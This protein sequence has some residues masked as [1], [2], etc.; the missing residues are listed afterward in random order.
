MKTV[1]AQLILLMTL[2]ACQPQAEKK[3]SCGKNESFDA[4]SRSC[5]SITSLSAL[6]ASPIQQIPVNSLSSES[7]N[8]DTP[9]IVYL[10]Y[11]DANLDSALSCSVSAGA[12][13]S[14][15]ACAC[16][17]GVC[18]FTLSS[19]ANFYGVST[20]NYTVTDND[21]PSLSTIVNVTVNSLDDAPVGTLVGSVAIFEDTLTPV[22]LTYT[23][24]E[25]D[26]ATSC[27]IIS[28]T[29]LGVTT[30]ACVAGLCTAQLQG[31][32]NVSGVGIANITYQIYA[33]G[34]FSI[35]Q[36]LTVDITALDDAPIGSTSAASTSEDIPVAITLGYTDVESD[37]AT[38]CNITSTTNVTVSTACA[39]V[40]GVCS[41]GI[42]PNANLNSSNSTLG[43]SYTVTANALTSVA[44]AVTLTTSAVDDIPVGSNV[45]TSTNEDT[46]ITIPLPFTDVESNLATSCTISALGGGTVGA[47]SCVTLPAS[48]CEVTF[49]PS[50]NLATSGSFQYTVTAGAGTS[51]VKTVTVTLNAVNDNPVLPTL[52][53]LSANEGSPFVISFNVDEGGGTDEDIQ[54]LNFTVTSDNPTLLPNGNISVSFTEAGDASDDIVTITMIPV[55]AQNGTATITVQLDDDGAPV[56]TSSATFN[57]TVN[58]VSVIHNG[59]KNLKALGDKVNAQGLV[60]EAKSV[61]VAWEDFSI[62]GASISGYNVYRFTGSYSNDIS[63]ATLLTPTPVAFGVNTYT[64]NSAALAA[65]ITYYY[66]V[67]PIDSV[68][69]LPTA[70]VEPATYAEIKMPEANTVLLH[71]WAVNKEVCGKLG[72]TVD[73]TNHYRCPYNGPGST[74]GFYDLGA[75][76]LIDRFEAGCNYTP[77]PKC[78]TSGCVGLGDPN[79][80]GCSGSACN[81]VTTS[82]DLFY[83]RTNG[84]CYY[85]TNGSVWTAIDGAF[86]SSALLAGTVDHAKAHLPP[87]T[88]V[89]QAQASQYCTEQGK[90]LITRKEFIAAAAWDLSLNE[91]DITNAEIG[92]NLASTPACNSSSGS[93]LTYTNG[94]VPPSASAD[95]LPGT[96]VSSIRSVR[97]GSTATAAC[98]SRYGVQDL[99]G[100]LDEWSTEEINCVSDQHCDT[101]TPS[102]FQFST[103]IYNF[104]GTTGPMLDS[105]LDDV[106]D[107]TGIFSSWLFENT[108]NLSTKFY[109]PMGLPADDDVAALDMVPD[110]NVGANIT[111]GQLHQDTI[112]IDADQIVLAGGAGGMVNGGHFSSGSSSGRYNL[113]FKPQNTQDIRTGFRCIKTAP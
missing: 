41:V 28:S 42:T 9:K 49:T 59:W 104:D 26:A 109:L 10:T 53:N 2:V 63:Q 30:C 76:Q 112:N 38:A 75:H 97:S 8:E 61:T 60:L 66:V 3:T 71:R 93:G 79:V 14:A 25:A 73:E 88:K 91:S 100:N 33:N 1:F 5:K 24:V 52:S 13:L 67:R 29:N 19:A 96:L 85:T 113:S 82:V 32:A 74:A 80:N 84:T 40:A 95:T 90:R 48:Q 94:V 102:D 62:F 34:S 37:V 39:C 20:F 106:E 44:K 81:I 72:Q 55:G 35:P 54:N 58:P 50:L 99:S 65:G 77:A 107:L 92:A 46:A 101:I 57:V 27:S 83:D 36:F 98:S 69:S 22:G 43:F 103:N 70:T 16:S 51:A 89:T 7:M 47:C 31:T 56:G 4:A 18:S 12:N 11:T 17:S 21:G 110:F 64:D 105:D 6:T 45:A 15:G 86:T 87:M 111:V 68:Y 23:D 108:P 78:S